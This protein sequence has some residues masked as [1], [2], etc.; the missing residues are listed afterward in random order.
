MLMFPSGRNQ[1][2]DLYYKLIDWFLHEWN[3]GM[4]KVKSTSD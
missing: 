2:I 4:K 1:L 3:I